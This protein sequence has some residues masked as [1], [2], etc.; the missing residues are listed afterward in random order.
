MIKITLQ[1]TKYVMHKTW[2]SWTKQESKK[3]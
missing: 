3:K 2:C 1:M